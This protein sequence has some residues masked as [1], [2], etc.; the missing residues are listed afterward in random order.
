LHGKDVWVVGLSPFDR[1]VYWF[2]VVGKKPA[3]ATLFK[4]PKSAYETAKLIRGNPPAK[5]VTGDLGL[6]DVS[7]E[8]VG[9]KVGLG[10]K[11]DPKQLTTGDFSTGKRLPPITERQVK[12]GRSKSPR[13]TPKTP[14]LRR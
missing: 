5:K 11:P 14:R 7:V 13:I 3:G 8:P 6:M 12:L 9:E 2:T 10:F 1:S 4:G